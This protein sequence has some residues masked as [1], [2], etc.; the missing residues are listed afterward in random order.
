MAIGP[1]KDLENVVDQ[2]YKAKCVKT[3]TSYVIQRTDLNKGNEMVGIYGASWNGETTKYDR[4]K[5]DSAGVAE[6]K[7]TPLKLM[8]PQATPLLKITQPKSDSNSVTSLH[9]R[10]KSKF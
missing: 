2:N 6:S 1:W 9:V 3:Q 8:F 4:C 7:S 10:D 5:S